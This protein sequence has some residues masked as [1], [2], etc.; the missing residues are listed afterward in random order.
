MPEGTPPSD[1]SSPDP[2]ARPDAAPVPPTGVEPQPGDPHPHRRVLTSAAIAVA[3]LLGGLGG[4]ALLRPDD[5]PPAESLTA[6]PRQTAAPTVATPEPTQNASARP[7]TTPSTGPGQVQV[8][9][10]V[11]GQGRADILYDD[12]NGEKIW[13]DAV[14]LPWRAN[15][16]TDRRD[17]VLVQVSR[18]VGTGDSMACSVTID[19]GTPVTERVSGAAWRASCFG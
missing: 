3:L 10:E 11:T 13:L 14:Q 7:A 16:R 19:G 6:D 1:P 2:S 18:T 8:V 5:Q 17:Q 12:A 4:Y 9:Y 15:I